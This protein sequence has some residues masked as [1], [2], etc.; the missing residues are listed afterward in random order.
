[1]KLNSSRDIAVTIVLYSFFICTVSLSI[2]LGL[3]YVPGWG[4]RDSFAIESG[5]VEHLQ[6]NKL[7]K[8]RR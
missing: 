6:T 3:E 5:L 2:I 4:S 8:I 1:M 7:L